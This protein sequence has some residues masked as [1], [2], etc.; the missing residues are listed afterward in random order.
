[1]CKRE[2]GGG[3]G[4]TR[5]AVFILL[6][7]RHGSILVLWCLGASIP[8]MH[9]VLLW[10]P[11]SPLPVWIKSEVYINSMH[12][13]CDCVQLSDL[14]HRHVMQSDVHNLEVCM[15]LIYT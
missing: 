2:R 3:E 5:V 10:R 15:L 7:V 6:V 1:M 13:L 14:V 4:A 12:T 11:Y 8:F 9:R